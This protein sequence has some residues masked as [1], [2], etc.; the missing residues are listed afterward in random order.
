[1][2]QVA[3]GDRFTCAVVVVDTTAEVLCWGTN[4]AGQLGDVDAPSGAEPHTVALPEGD[5]V[6]LTAGAQFVCARHA[7]GRVSCWGNNWQGALGHGPL[8]AGQPPGFVDDLEDA[9]DLDAGTDHA[10]AVRRDGS[11]VCWGRG[12]HGRLGDGVQSDDH[13]SVSIVE[14]IG[15]GG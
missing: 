15:F 10:C 1:V 8:E 11:V 14:V 13:R 2:Q 3:T 5:V 12:Q 9:T 6:Q 4:G 7:S